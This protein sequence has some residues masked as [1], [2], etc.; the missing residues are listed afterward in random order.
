[1]SEP[2][3]TPQRTEEPAQRGESEHVVREVPATYGTTMEA[4]AL[5]A[6]HLELARPWPNLVG[7]RL[8]ITV[9]PLPE[10]REAAS[11]DQRDSR[12]RQAIE[13]AAR[14]RQRLQRKYGV[15]PSC[16]DDI[17]AMREERDED[18][19]AARAGRHAIA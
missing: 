15:L 19:E 2:T 16:V 17:R 14:F 13:R 5:D 8:L 18:L 1:M 10:I 12:Q 11:A 6:R 4:V 7:Q 3:A 9:V